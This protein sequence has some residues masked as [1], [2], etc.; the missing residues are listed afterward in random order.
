[1]MY[2]LKQT[3]LIIL[4]NILFF[5]NAFA[6]NK[7]M[8]IIENIA[9]DIQIKGKII[10]LTQQA[11]E[12]HKV[13][14]FV[15]T[16]KWYVHPYAHGGDGK[17]WAS[18]DSDGVWKI[19]TVNRGFSATFIAALVVL[20]ERNIPASVQDINNVKNIAILVKKLEG[21]EDYGKI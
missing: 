12:N 10:G 4:L 9:S 16:D 21:T 2:L 5:S 6:Q 3:L 1:M 19:S 13:V 17:S 11:M 7:P 8:I 18:I 14:V 15:K 20:K